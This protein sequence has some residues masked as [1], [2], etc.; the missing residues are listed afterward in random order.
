M[1]GIVLTHTWTDGGTQLLEQIECRVAVQREAGDYLQDGLLYCGK[2]HTAKQV[3]VEI[4]W[5]KD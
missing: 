2:C 5:Q 4:P 3:L 1:G